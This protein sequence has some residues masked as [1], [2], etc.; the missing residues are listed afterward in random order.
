MSQSTKTYF[1]S[2]R[3]IGETNPFLKQRKTSKK[4]FDRFFSKQQKNALHIHGKALMDIPTSTKR[5][6][7][8]VYISIYAKSGI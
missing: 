5:T 7:D 8:R 1:Y 3:H 6:H 4:A 2:F